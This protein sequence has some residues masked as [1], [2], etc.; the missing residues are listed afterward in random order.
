[1]KFSV[2]EKNWPL[3]IALAAFLIR[4]VY[5]LE[6]KSHPAFLYPMVDELWHLNWAREIIDGNF[7]GDQAYFRGP[8]YPYLLALFLKVTGQSLIWTRLIQLALG[9]VSSVLLYYVGRQYFSKTVGLIAGFIYAAYGPAIFHEAS[10]L[11]PV[12]YI[13]LLLISFLILKKFEGKARPL[14]W[15]GPGIILGLAAIAR[16]NILLLVPLLMIWIYYTLRPAKTGEKKMTLG[17]KLIPP[18]IYLL[19]ILIPVFS[20]TLRNYVVTGEFILISSQGGV[21]FYIGNNP[22]ADGLTMLMPEVAIDE[23]LPWSEFREATRQAAEN[24]TGRALS[25]AEASSFWTTK[26]VTFIL[27]NPGRFLSLT[28]KKLLYLLSGFENSD[29]TD[30]Y[31]ARNYS[32]LLSGLIWS[33]PIFFP[34]GLLVPLAVIGLVT[35]FRRR[36]ELLPLYIMIVGYIPTIVLFLVTS[37]HR[38]P[39]VPFLIIFAAAGV[40]ALV[41]LIK[42]RN[43]RRLGLTAAGLVLLLILFNRTYFELGF[44]NISQIHFNLALAH[45]RRGDLPEAEKEYLKALE[46]NAF[47]VTLRNNLGYVQ[48]RLQ[49]YD[50][51]L[52]SFQQAIEVEPSF[53]PPYHNAALI[54]TARDNPERA[55]RLYIE[56][57]N[58]DPDMY[59]SYLNLGELY[60][61][62]GDTLKAELTYLQAKEVNPA[63]GTAYFKLGS[64]YG[65]LRRYDEADRMFTD[66]AAFD[67][68]TAGDLANWGNIYYATDRIDRALTL[69][70]RAVELDNRFARG[71]FNLALAFIRG[72]Y[73]PDSARIYLNRTLEINPAFEPARVLLNQL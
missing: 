6:M 9:A 23:S 37:R 38:L 30:I 42:K 26:A 63:T 16:P 17:K 27:D 1:M 61:N 34:F 5:L 72:G 60:L 18:L 24:E 54:F 20:V 69:Y 2:R 39:L 41:H 62:T 56:A 59:Q 3:V 10:L 44:Q 68:L 21:N 31:Y 7:W 28:F 51:A 45:E 46:T 29:N 73:P 66:G 4:L 12:I 70:R 25:E 48:Y 14:I 35:T 65:R 49:K 19:G 11:I 22:D 36:R 33:K 52:N 71:Y 53:A 58:R 55:I 40:M 15:F 64:L 67:S 47:S 57:L 13:P 8:L 32:Y 50:E 43:F